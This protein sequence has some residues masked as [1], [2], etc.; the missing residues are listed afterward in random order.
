MILLFALVLFGSLVQY[1]DYHIFVRITIGAA[2][3]LFVIVKAFRKK[4]RARS[5]RPNQSGSTVFIILH[6]ADAL[7]NSLVILI[8][9]DQTCIAR[10]VSLAGFAIL[11][12]QVRTKLLLSHPGVIAATERLL[13]LFILT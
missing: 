11:F 12:S 4:L 5:L 2:V 7:S 10:F 8:K 3:Q 1:L 13:L 9:F 6:F